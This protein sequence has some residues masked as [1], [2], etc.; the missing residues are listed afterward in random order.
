MQMC[1]FAVFTMYSMLSQLMPG[2]I[3]SAAVH[4][5]APAPAAIRAHSANGLPWAMHAAI[6]A[7]I[8]MWQMTKL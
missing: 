2:W 3:V 7:A 4:A 8:V 1:Y 6:A 5:S